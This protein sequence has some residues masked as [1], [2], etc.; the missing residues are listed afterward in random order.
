MY[1][2]RIVAVGKNAS[3][4]LVAM[5]RVSSRSFPNRRTQTVGQAI[6]IVPKEGHESDIY[7]NPYIAYN[8]LRLVGSYA[9]V[10]NGTQVDPIAEKLEAGMRMRD[11]M[12]SV[13]H[14]MD[15]EHDHL[16]T[17]RIV[18]VVDKQSRRCTLGIIRHDALLVQEME[19]ENGE[20]F[21]VATYEHN[22]PGKE[23][24][25]DHFDV[26]TAAEACDYILGKGVFSELERPISAAC[27]VETEQGFSVSAKD[28]SVGA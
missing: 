20:A 10:G 12:V 2:G 23:F 25:D 26:A 8:C 16:N 1:V 3:G 22:A 24:R 7:K 13:L 6:A 9:V 15:Y 4:R 19:V 5:Y 21:Y 17:P 18:G 27:V 14:G 28:V 11:A